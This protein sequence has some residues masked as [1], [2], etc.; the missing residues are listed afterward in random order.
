MG[1]A[2]LIVTHLINHLLTKVLKFKSL[3]E[4]LSTFYPDLTLQI[5]E[6]LK[7]LGVSLTFM[8][9]VKTGGKNLDPG[10]TKFYSM[11]QKE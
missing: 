1:A 3:M 6:Y 7:S 8:S 10:P 9:I 4:I 5:T 11:T 2:A